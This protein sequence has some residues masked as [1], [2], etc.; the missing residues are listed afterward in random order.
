MEER[1]KL[2]LRMNNIFVSSQYC[3]LANWWWLKLSQERMVLGRRLKW[4]GEY[5]RQF[6]RGLDDISVSCQILLWLV[7][8]FHFTSLSW[9]FFSA[10]QIHLITPDGT[11]VRPVLMSTHTLIYLFF[12]VQ[13]KHFLMFKMN[14]SCKKYL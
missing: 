1:Q 6:Q 13:K 4:G 5:K 9:S 10:T 12:C 2:V 3:K 8:N 7:L 11:A 14:K